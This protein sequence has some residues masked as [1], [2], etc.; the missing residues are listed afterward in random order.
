M[1]FFPVQ[2]TKESTIWLLDT[3]GFDDTDRNDTEVLKEIAAYLVMP[4]LYENRESKLDG[5]I[6]LHRINDVRMG[7]SAQTN[8]FMFQKLCG[9]DALAR[10]IL[11]TTMWEKVTEDEGSHREAELKDTDNFWGG[12]ISC[13]S[14]VHR[15]VNTRKSAMDIVEHFVSAGQRRQ[16]GMVLDLQKEMV[17]DK[18]DLNETGAG[19]E[20]DNG[21]AKARD[22][23]QRDIDQLQENLIEAKEQH[24]EEMIAAVQKKQIEMEGKIERAER[25]RDRLKIS[26][27]ELY[28]EKLDSMQQIIDD[29][30]NNPLVRSHPLPDGVDRWTAS[31]SLFGDKYWFDGQHSGLL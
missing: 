2:Y 15:H 9:K 11:A 14:T 22:G 5:I 18:L 13:G 21:L 1:K 23:F 26:L 28:K 27:E 31:M 20:V 3:P 29:L 8:L 4:A 16:G 10:V 30:R 12:M 19:K 17:D 24:N 7:G 25:E 6:Y